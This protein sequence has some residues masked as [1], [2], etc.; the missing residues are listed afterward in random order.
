[1]MGRTAWVLRLHNVG[2]LEKGSTSPETGNI[3]TIMIIHSILHFY[4]QPRTRM[5]DLTHLLHCNLS[6]GEQ[7]SD[8][9]SL[10]NVELWLSSYW[11]FS[12]TFNI[13]NRCEGGCVTYLITC[14]QV[15]CA[16]FSRVLYHNDHPT[17]SYTGRR[18]C[19]CTAILSTEE[20]SV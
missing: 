4:S 2:T 14:S 1:M 16:D 12:S 13:E 9:L 20:R 5:P 6:L 3:P 19:P 7:S 11:S 17:T 15:P 10:P 18:P 8:R